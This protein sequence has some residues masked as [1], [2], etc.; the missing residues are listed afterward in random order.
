MSE[1]KSLT[2]LP[3]ASEVH[4][5][6]RLHEILIEIWGHKPQYKAEEE[7]GWPQPNISRW[8]KS[9]R[10]G[11]KIIL[12]ITPVLRKKGYNPDYLRYPKAAKMLEVKDQAEVKVIELYE[13]IISLQK[14]NSKLKEEALKESQE[15]ARRLASLQEQN[16]K[17]IKQ[18]TDMVKEPQPDSK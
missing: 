9:K 5:G 15:M 2:S 18:I 14:E 11:D 17:L 10:L 16:L 4:F 13:Q 7:A 1:E 6:R 3:Q 12:R 8:I